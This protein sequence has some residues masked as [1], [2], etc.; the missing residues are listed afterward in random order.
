MPPAGAS[1]APAAPQAPNVS[2]GGSE[3]P[4]IPVA[5]GP[6]PE[7]PAA[8]DAGLLAQQRQV[9]A[10]LRPQS[11]DAR[12]QTIAASIPTSEERA[13]LQQK[14]FTEITNMNLGIDLATASPTQIMDALKQ[15][16]WDEKASFDYAMGG[17]DQ[18]IALRREEARGKIVDEMKI[19]LTPDTDINYLMKQVSEKGGWQIDDPTK[20]YA[21]GALD[22]VKQE[23]A[24]AA[25]NVE[26]SAVTN[27]AP[28]TPQ[29]E[30]AT[31]QPE[32]VSQTPRTAEDVKEEAAA[33]DVIDIVKGREK[34]T[35]S[36]EDQAV[37]E[38]YT[39]MIM[40]ESQAF[41]EFYQALKKDD[42]AYAAELKHKL[43]LYK[44]MMER[45][46]NKYYMAAGLALFIIYT[47]G[48]AILT[49][50]QQH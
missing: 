46:K 28:A 2:V 27:E 4:R 34:E 10:E 19:A 47:L 13:A 44:R 15:R 25:G 36:V 11:P 31:G 32:A 37:M 45:K 16:G 14:S 40:K 17:R 49:G 41:S 50:G 35:L 43:E 42:P 3:G 26:P 38:T 30:A 5:T 23:A 29:A 6:R 18:A 48:G 12:L 21:Q 22:L 39:K 24:Q 33:K 20:A 1:A 9:A 8:P 7:Q